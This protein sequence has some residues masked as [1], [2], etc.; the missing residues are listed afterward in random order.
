MPNSVVFGIF[1][2]KE[3]V[4]TA[5]VEMKRDGFRNAEISDRMSA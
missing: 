3:Q 1:S 5:I 2:T 4:D